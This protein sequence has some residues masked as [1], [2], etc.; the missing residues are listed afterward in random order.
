MFCSFLKKS[1]I[2]SIITVPILMVGSPVWAA[3]TLGFT[4][5]SSN[6]AGDAAIGEAQMTVTVTDSLGGMNLA[7]TQVLFTFDNIGPDASSIT[8]IYFDDGTLLGAP[9]IF[10][11]PPDVEYQQGGSPGNL[12]AA[13]Q[14]LPPFV[15]TSDFTATPLP[16]TQ[17]NG[18]NPGETL[19]LLFD[20]QAGQTLSDTIEDL[21]NGDLRIGIH[22]QGFTSGGSESFVNNDPPIIPPGGNG[23]PEP[24]TTTLGMLGLGALSMAIRRRIA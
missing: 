20:L 24:V 12:P 9:T 11:N 6:L 14:A 21:N 8:Q 3:L 22:V 17:P 2:S 23:I 19:G 18:I 10:D 13:N 15:A 5:I 7:D 4:N 1:F 16:P